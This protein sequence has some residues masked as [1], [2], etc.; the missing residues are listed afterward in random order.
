MRLI[1]YV[2]GKRSAVE[3]DEAEMIVQRFR[4]EIEDG[5]DENEVYKV[6]I[7]C[8]SWKKEAIDIIEP[9]LRSVSRTVKFVDFADIIAGRMTDEGLNI[10]K[11][12][13]D[14]FLDANLIEINLSDNA[15][16]PRGLERVESMF[17]NTIDGL[18]RLYLNNCGLSKE[19]MEMLKSY[20]CSETNG[21][22]IS[23]TLTDLVLDKNMIGVEGAEV[24]GE[25]L[26]QCT[27]LKYFSYNGCRPEAKGT[28]YLCQGILNLTEEVK[29]RNQPIMLQRIELEDCTFASGENENDAI[30]PFSR[31]LK[32]CSR[33]R[34]LNMKDG[35]LEIGGLKLLVNA[36]SEGSPNLTHLYLDGQG[37]LESDGARILSNFLHGQVISLLSLH[38]DWN[39]LGDE[40][41]SILLEPFS[42][43]RN[44]LQTLSLNGN[45]IEQQGA[46]AIV[47]A[48][49]P[50]LK[51]LSL[52]DNDDIHQNHIRKKY[53]DVAK[54]DD[55]DDD[56]GHDEN[57]DSLMDALVQQ[58]ENANPFQ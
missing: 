16:G 53:G 39:D 49:L 57:N 50:E 30:I 4:R 34:H 20:I 33:L 42:A 54:L 55:I 6:D 58:M 26:S 38:M 28:K 14:M 15:M 36:L 44:V 12:L 1:F 37:Q 18:Q 11:Q 25:I 2:G 43:S 5:D 17:T 46:K 41:V 10:T 21:V 32:Q 29:N 23:D 35:A 51:L 45:L 47:R 24:V 56:D 3:R 27:Q 40:G 19:S 7:S 9:F 13:A 48:L 52:T 31:A 8:R 22:K